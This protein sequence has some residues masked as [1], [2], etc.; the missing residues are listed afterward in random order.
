MGGEFGLH[1]KIFNIPRLQFIVVFPRSIVLRSSGQMKQAFL[2]ISH[3]VL[4]PTLAA[5]FTVE[6]DSPSYLAEFHGDATMGCRFQPGSQDLNLSVIWHRISPDPIVEVYRLENGQEDLS[7][8]NPHYQGRARLVLT[9]LINGWAKL[10]LSELRIGDSGVYQC[11][12]EMGGADY[13]QTT[14]TVKASYKS[15]TKHIQ[16]SVGD[17][18][19]LVCESQGY[20]L[21]TFSWSKGHQTLTS[22]DTSIQNQDQLFQV[23]SKITVKSSE[24]NNYTCALLQTDASPNNLSA[25][26]DIPDELQVPVIINCTTPTLYVALGTTLMLAGIIAVIIIRKRRQRERSKDSGTP[27]KNNLL[28]FPQT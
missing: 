23:T 9:E 25:S 15:I 13:K 20:P 19:D 7:S 6:V 17:D 12:V 22:N 28:D 2:F 8:Q 26:F 27:C 14:L 21:A 4:W 5:L 10:E 18:V 3:L 11:L 1:N 16:R 24:K